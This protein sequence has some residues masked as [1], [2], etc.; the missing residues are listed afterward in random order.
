MT[1]LQ[2]REFAQTAQGWKTVR[3]VTD[4]SDFVLC[5]PEA[6]SAINDSEGTAPNYLFSY[7]SGRFT[8]MSDL[9]H[10]TITSFSGPA[11]LEEHQFIYDQIVRFFGGSPDSRLTDYIADQLDVK[12]LLVTREDGLFTSVGALESRYKMIEQKPAYQVYLRIE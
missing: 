6:Y 8:P 4:A 5:S 12:A 7:Y 10:Y 3:Q 11:S 9:D 2:H 1:P